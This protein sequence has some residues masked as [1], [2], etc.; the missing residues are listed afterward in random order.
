MDDLKLYGKN[1]R[2]VALGTLVNIV[3]IFSKDIGMEI[4]RNKRVYCA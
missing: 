4:I 3:R 1:E 2:Q